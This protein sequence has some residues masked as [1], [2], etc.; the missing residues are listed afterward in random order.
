MGD[1]HRNG[2][3]SVAATESCIDPQLLS[4]TYH[5]RS[6][7]TN[8]PL[9]RSTDREMIEQNGGGDAQLFHDGG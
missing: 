2:Q 6:D 5:P 4:I 8:Q 3:P 7:L 1:G 9:P